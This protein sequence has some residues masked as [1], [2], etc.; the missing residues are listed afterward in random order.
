VARRWGEGG[1]RAAREPS[2]RFE[3]V[4]RV[5][6]GRAMKKQEGGKDGKRLLSISQRGAREGRRKRVTKVRWYFRSKRG[7]QTARENPLK[8]WVKRMRHVGDVVLLCYY[9]R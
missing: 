7:A 2:G 5:V 8:C 4:V 1:E 3:R 9:K 6:L